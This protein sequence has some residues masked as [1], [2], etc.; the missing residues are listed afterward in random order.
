[1]YYIYNDSGNYW[2]SSK[3]FVPTLIGRVVSVEIKLE[4]NINLM[5]ILE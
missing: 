4:N 2:K 5:I 1:M 3:N